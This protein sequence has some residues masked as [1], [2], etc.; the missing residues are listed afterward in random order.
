MARLV[1]SQIGWAYASFVVWSRGAYRRGLTDNQE[2]WAA[3]RCRLT[4]D[5]PIA[6]RARNGRIEE[7]DQDRATCS[8]GGHP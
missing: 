1:T 2:L 3:G 8:C 7:G 4:L 5:G 6:N